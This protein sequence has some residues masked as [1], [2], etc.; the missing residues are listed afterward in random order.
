MKQTLFVTSL[1]HAKLIAL[2][3][4]T[5][6]CVWLRVVIEYIRSTSGLSSIN[7]APIT[8]HED[9]TVCTSKNLH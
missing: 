6:E 3:E 2:H 1:N 5:R 4:A 7:D 9:N 8:I